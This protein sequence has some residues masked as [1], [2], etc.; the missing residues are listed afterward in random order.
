M[1]IDGILF[2]YNDMAVSRTQKPGQDTL[3]FKPGTDDDRHTPFMECL[4]AMNIP[5]LGSTE[6]QILAQYFEDNLD[7]F[8]DAAM[9]EYDFGQIPGLH[10]TLHQSICQWFQNED[11]WCRWMELREQL[12]R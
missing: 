9:V 11:N 5:A 8:E 10:E 6:I 7:D 12:E 1:P 2:T 3:I 4:A